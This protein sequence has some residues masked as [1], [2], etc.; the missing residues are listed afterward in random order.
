MDLKQLRDNIDDIDSSILSLFL[1]RMELCRS[2]AEYKKEH[3]L[4]VFQGGREEEVIRRIKELTGDPDLE[5]GT[6][7]LFTT[8]MD[9]SKLLQ[10][11]KLLADAP[12]YE[13]TAPDFENASEI[14][15]QG[16]S[17]ANSEAAARLIFGD[18]KLRFFPT[19][20]DVF[21]AVESGEIQY[22]VIPLNNS[23]AGSVSSAYDLMA[24]YSVY[25]VKTACV[26]INHC[27][28]AKNNIPLSEI[29]CVY[30][31]PQ[32][33]SQCGDFLSH[34][35]LET[36]EYDN[37]A[38]A[39][40]MVAESNENIAAVC[41]VDC[42][43]QLG[44]HIIA[45]NIADCSVNRTRFICITRNLQ[46][47]PESDIISVM[48][49]IPHTEGSLSRLLTKFSVN[50][51]NLCRI[52][53]R[54][55][56]DGSFEVMFYLDFSGKITDPDVKALLSDLASNLEYFRLLGTSEAE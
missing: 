9:I 20:E 27:L 5:N 6:A 29:S 45:E 18:K 31:H 41:S 28:A 1:Q 55:V 48:L 46:V 36:A 4:P 16:T 37:T 54:P 34:Y 17:G 53:N 39:A 25:I 49:K 7:M 10:N 22:G 12:D 33:L 35:G 24:K 44:L 51:M 26:D 3:N 23:T 21:K 11:R 2:V 40:A 13:F 50:G 42:A 8:I 30:S 52:E 19:F 56:K 32:A 43:K 14:G 15:C 47:A 38:T